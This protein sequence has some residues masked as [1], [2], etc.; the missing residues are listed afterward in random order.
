MS[1]PASLRLS[2]M[3]DRCADLGALLVEMYVQAVLIRCHN[4]YKHFC[5]MRER[6]NSIFLNDAVVLIL[7]IMGTKHQF[8]EMSREVYDIKYP[9]RIE[10]SFK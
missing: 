5:M 2:K 3:H 6:S 7:I 4:R 8:K 1:G 10:I 9:F